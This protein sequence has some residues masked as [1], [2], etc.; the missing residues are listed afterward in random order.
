M[1]KREV[2]VQDSSV[3]VKWFSREE[4]SEGALALMEA[5]AGGR[6]ELVVLELLFCEVA[7]ALRYNPRFDAGRLGDAIEQLFRLHMRIVPIDGELMRKAGEIAFDGKVTLYDALP[8]ALA[9]MEG[10]TCVTADEGTKYARLK[11][12]GYP[13][14]LLQQRLMRL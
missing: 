4:G 13:I 7:N 2:A 14:E 9:K 6:I 12:N 3:A 10:S 5:H 8:V 11:P 1:A